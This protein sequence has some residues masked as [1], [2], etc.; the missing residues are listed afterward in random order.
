MTIIKDKELTISTIEKTDLKRI[1]ELT[2]KQENPE[3]KKW[4]APYYTHESMSYEEFLTLE[5]RYVNAESVLVI[6]VDGEIIGQVGY[7]WEHE[8][9]KW[10]EM[11]LLIYEPHNW[12]KGYGSRVLTMWTTH[13]F[14]TLPLVRVGY[15]TWSGNERMIRAGEKLGF[16]M[17]AR[18]RRVRYW[19]GHYYDSIRMGLLREEWKKSAAF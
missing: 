8:P 10:L 7:Y 3:W 6:K 9:S 13:L 18:I 11:G 19:N 16:T 2:Y 5:D 15:A 4:D 1:W 14:E 17:E 12:G